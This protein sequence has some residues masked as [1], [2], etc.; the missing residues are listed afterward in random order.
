MRSEPTFETLILEPVEIVGV[1]GYGQWSMQLR[2]R[3]KTVAQ[4]QWV[5][6]REF[7]KRLRKALN[8]HG[9]EVP[10]PILRPGSAEPLSS[11]RAAP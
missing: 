10:Y 3:M 7:R 9:I 5:V 8:R 6:G 11:P 1:V 4:R 2:I